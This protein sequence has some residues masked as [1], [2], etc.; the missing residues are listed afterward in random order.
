MASY[1]T[2][3]RY[4]ARYKCHAC[5]TKFKKTL[6]DPNAPDP[7]CPE[8]SAA[9]LPVR[10]LDFNRPPPAAVGMNN[11]VR[12]QDL[13]A[14]I[15]MS[16]YKMTD[17]RDARHEGDTMAPKLDPERQRAADNFF[18]QGSAAT[19][20]NPAVAQHVQKMNTLARSGAL[21][22]QHDAVTINRM[23]DSKPQ[24]RRVGSGKL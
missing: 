23:I 3:P 2:R 7:S 18:A 10:G 19:K 1:D 16:D 12:A 11:A 6:R 13:T 20:S 4:I 24:F 21:A 17:L 5:G 22:Q 8:C 14:E 9:P 15:V